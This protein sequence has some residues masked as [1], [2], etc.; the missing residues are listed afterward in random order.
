MLY[1]SADFWTDANI[2][3]EFSISYIEENVSL[4]CGNHW[5]GLKINRNI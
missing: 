1:E 4:N 5:T 2:K 3:Q